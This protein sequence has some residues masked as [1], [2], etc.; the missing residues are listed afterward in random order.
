MKSAEFKLG[1]I[2][3]SHQSLLVR[4]SHTYLILTIIK[5]ATFKEQT[6]QQLIHTNA[7]KSEQYSCREAG[8]LYALVL[9]PLSLGVHGC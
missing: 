7:S 4:D 6:E 8:S 9:S 3:V 5:S 1:L 2:S